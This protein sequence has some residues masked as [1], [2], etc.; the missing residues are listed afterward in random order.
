MNWSQFWQILHQTLH[1]FVFFVG[2]FYFIDKILLRKMLSS[3]CGKKSSRQIYITSFDSSSSVLAPPLSYV[4]HEFSAKQFIFFYFEK[5]KENFHEKSIDF[6]FK[7][8]SQFEW[9]EKFASLIWTIRVFFL[10][11]STICHEICACFSEVN[12][13]N[14]PNNGK[15]PFLQNN[16]SI[17][18]TKQSQLQVQLKRHL[19]LKSAIRQPNSKILF[20]HVKVQYSAKKLD[21]KKIFSKN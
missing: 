12:N 6:P 3:I 5:K 17:K 1:S 18:I 15:N 11:I 19:Q 9:S 13:N 21:K 14:K 2:G 20:Q 7:C 4:K 16:F 8:F 10:R